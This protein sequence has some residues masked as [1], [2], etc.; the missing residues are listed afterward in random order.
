MYRYFD[1]IKKL[2]AQGAEASE[3]NSRITQN[4]LLL[5]FDL[6]D[7]GFAMGWDA[8]KKIEAALSQDSPIEFFKTLYV[9]PCYGTR[10]LYAQSLP[11]CVSRKDT[12][13]KKAGNGDIYDGFGRAISQHHALYPKMPMM[14]GYC[15]GMLGKSG[16]PGYSSAVGDCGPHASI[17]I[18]RR[19]NAQRNKCQVLIQNTYGTGKDNTHPA[20]ENE[21]GKI[22]VDE[23][24]LANNLLNYDEFVAPEAK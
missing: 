21:G 15:S 7:Y 8:A 22:W 13:I 5:R 23:S 6:M 1:E 19:Y 20:W 18:G 17:V 3:L 9:S 4:A 16:G 2:R 24:T 10:K 14:I 12:E 11:S